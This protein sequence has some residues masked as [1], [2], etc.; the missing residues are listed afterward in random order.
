MSHLIEA[1]VREEH[2]VA[3][4]TSAD[5]V[6][7]HAAGFDVI[8]CHCDRQ[9]APLVG[10]FTTPCLAT[11]HAPFELS[12]H[13]ASSDVILVPTSN[14]QLAAGPIDNLR[15]PIPHALPRSLYTYR[16]RAGAHLAYSG[17]ISRDSGVQEAISV[18]ERSGL[19]L[20]L[21]SEQPLGDRSYFSEIF[22]PML[23]GSP[24]VHL[25]DDVDDRGRNILLGGALALLAPYDRTGAFELQVIE[26]LACGT[27]VIAWAETA[28]ADIIEHGIS[29][30]VVECTD[31]ATEAVKR[32]AA[33]DRRACRNLFERRFDVREIADRY[34][35]L[36]R[37]L[38]HARDAAMVTVSGCLRSA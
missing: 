16:P 20:H 18:A 22:M 38:V 23:R 36:Y 4:F 21:A 7:R 34:L 9:M 10:H 12:A 11:L 25:A 5:D 13:L 31:T 1:L 35:Q 14:R 6:Q 26:A 3:V 17:P 15:G 19:A 2:E 30:F 24:Q 8:H 37:E 29:G 32:V 33:L 28:A 27:P